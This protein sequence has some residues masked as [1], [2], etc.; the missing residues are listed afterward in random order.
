MVRLNNM[1][2]YAYH[3]CLESERREGNRFRVDFAYDYDMRKAAHTDDLRE[4]IDYSV[5][6][7]LIRAE[8]DIPANLLEHLATRILN[9]LI[10]HFP[11]TFGAVDEG[12]P[13]GEEVLAIELR[14]QGVADGFGG[15]TG[16]IGHV[17]HGARVA[18]R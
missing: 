2:F 9:T 13:V 14:Q 6:Y 4:A 1:E 16:A 15:N 18:H 17:I 10:D 8:M 3:G 5:I 11:R 12:Q 7:E